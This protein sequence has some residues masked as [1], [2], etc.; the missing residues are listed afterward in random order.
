MSVARWVIEGRKT[1]LGKD[2]RVITT[3]FLDGAMR[4]QGDREI[5]K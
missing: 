2:T 5:D 1:S 3:I 4:R